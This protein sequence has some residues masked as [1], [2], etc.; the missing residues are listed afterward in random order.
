MTKF[1]IQICT[2]CLFLILSFG[3]CHYSF[4]Q[5]NDLEFHLDVNSATILL[6]NIL[7]PNIDLSGRGFH[8]RQD[9]PKSLAAVEVLDLWEQDIGLH[10]A[11][12]IQYDLWEIQEAA[13]TKELQEKLLNNYEIIF[14]KITDAKG[15]VIL[16]IF[17]MPAGLGKVLD[18][19]SA[20]RDFK[21]YKAMIKGMMRYLSCEKKYNI[22]YEVWTAP[23]REDFFLG[24]RQDYLSIY[25]AVAE[26]AK[27][28][29]AE[30]KIHIPVGGPS[31]SRWFQS[32]EGNTVVTPERSLIYSLIKFCSHYRL[33]LDFISWHSYSSD[34]R[35]DK[36]N[37]I[38]KKSVIPLIRNWLSYFRFDQATPL[39]VDEWNYDS[40]VSVPAE[41]YEKSHI[42]ASYIPSRLKNMYESGLD[43]Q[44]YF[45]LEDFQNI[46]DGMLKDTG[47]FS[48]DPE[49]SKYK[50]YP[51]AV[52]NVFRMLSKLGNTL[53]TLAENPNDEFVGVIATKSQGYLALI[54]YNY[55]D[56]LAARNYIFKNIVTL[57]S[58]ARKALS[59]MVKA[60]KLDKI[61]SRQSDLASLRAGKKLK[62]L[63]EKAQQLND[64]AAKYALSGRN[65]KISI[66]G[67]NTKYIYQRYKID[68]SCAFNCQFIPIE[69][70]ETQATELYQEMLNLDPYSVNLIV[71]QEKPP[72]PPPPPASAPEEAQGM[73]GNI[74]NATN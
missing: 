46:K 38:Y 24:R 25:R 40:G 63:L 68:S 59:R 43:Y 23:D 47:I 13:K 12:R 64:R 48:F 57:N 10:G 33:P 42:S 30:T 18:K 26:A 9:W 55:V 29:K 3:I 28:L 53:F 45:A 14:K 73:V 62:A 6:P 11:Y 22:W 1:K 8:A 70:K 49:A 44:F 65:I 16:D 15:V 56:P 69:E 27:E 17:G 61:I 52:Y 4:A 50:G 2:F 71:L 36:E 74:T 21:A 20:P 31:V 41:G 66:K 35:V 5:E 58:A 72:E 19:T 7:R 39:V 67:L 34:P 32:D 60:N 37:T 54:I 51:K